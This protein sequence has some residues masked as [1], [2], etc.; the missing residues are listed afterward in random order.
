MTGG[1]D[2]HEQEEVEAAE[3]GR[4]A[5]QPRT[6]GTPS[7]GQAAPDQQA[8]QQPAGPEA[9]GSAGAAANAAA[10]AQV[11]ADVDPSLAQARQAFIFLSTLYL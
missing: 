3:E 4:P 7:N 1:W 10:E 5:K 2:L 8:A 9:S 11:L 6:E